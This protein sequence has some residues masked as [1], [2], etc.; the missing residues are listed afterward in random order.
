METIE[1]SVG[2]LVTFLLIAGTVAAHKE[3]KQ[4]R[5]KRNERIRKNT[6]YRTNEEFISY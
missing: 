4:L 1:F 5:E 6:E 3:R 2:V